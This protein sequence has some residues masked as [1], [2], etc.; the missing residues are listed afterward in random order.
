MMTEEGPGPYFS[1]R[2]EGFDAKVLE[3]YDQAKGYAKQGAQAVSDKLNQREPGPPPPPV[4][5]GASAE[6]KK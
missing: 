5:E 2:F 6:K 3:K 4:V 1:K